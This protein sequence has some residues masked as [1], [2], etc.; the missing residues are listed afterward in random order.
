MIVKTFNNEFAIA[1][2]ARLAHHA[3]ALYG[4]EPLKI[5]ISTKPYGYTGS[6]LAARL[7]EAGIVCEFA[8]PDFL[9][10]MLTP[11]NGGEAIVR[12]EKALC[13]IERKAPMSAEPPVFHPQEKAMS[14]RAAALS[15]QETV[16]AAEAEGR[17]LA[18]AT[19]GCPPAVPIVV[20]GERID[21]HAVACFEYYGIKN[22]TVV[23]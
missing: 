5:T 21:R 19:V 20:C 12:L 17:V 10:L 1:S 8:D 6:A 22:C 9:V 14:I 11:E 2:K 13:A 23:K 18:A 4:D 16:P 3:Y 7:R 15:R